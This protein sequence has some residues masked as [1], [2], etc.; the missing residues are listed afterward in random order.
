MRSRVWHSSGQ[1]MQ[2]AVLASLP[3]QAAAWFHCTFAVLEMIRDGLNVLVVSFPC[4]SKDHRN[5]E[6]AT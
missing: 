2:G 4:P 3:E 6:G 5:D 1:N